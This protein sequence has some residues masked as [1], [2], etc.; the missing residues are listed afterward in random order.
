[1]TVSIERPLVLVGAGKMGSALLSGWLQGGL[2]PSLVYVREPQATDEIRALEAKGLKLNAPVAEIAAAQ[3]ALVLL[4]V[5]P[6]AMGA[7]LPELRPL[8]RPETVFLSIA[9]GTGLERLEELLGADVAA[10]RAMPNTP[11]AVGRGITVAHANGRVTE[12]QR[13]L[14]DGL[15]AAVGE[16][17]WVE[18]EGLIDAVTAI[19]GSGPAYV[20][21][22]VECLAAAGEGL[23]LDPALAMKLARETVS[24]SGEMLHRL[25]EPASE[26]RANVT[27]PGGTT[28]AALDVLMGEGGLSPLMRRAAVAA[29]DR[30]RELGK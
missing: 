24:G 29:R 8:V 19:S 27:S 12:A 7:V 13:A 22:L 9:A 11:A 21:Y 2:S 16:V 6:Q 1:M 3:P 25:P 26:L 23:G 30:A 5:K 15:L 4:A 17:G 10:I 20:F 18:A 28:A 14:A